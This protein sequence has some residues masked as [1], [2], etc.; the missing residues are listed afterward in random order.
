MSRVHLQA[1]LSRWARIPRIWR[2][3]TA[4]CGASP[5]FALRT[6]IRATG[7]SRTQAPL[8]G[9]RIARHAE[10][11]EKIDYPG[12]GKPGEQRGRGGP[13][14]IG[15]GGAQLPKQIEDRHDE[16]Q[17]GVLEQRYE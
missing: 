4:K 6:S 16:H 2:C 1:A 14:R 8:H 17:T 3:A 5:D 9:Q 11:G 10:I 15:E 12:K 7:L 13:G